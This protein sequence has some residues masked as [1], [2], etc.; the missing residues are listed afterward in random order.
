M[1]PT[2][3]PEASQ[4]IE[5]VRSLVAR[6]FPV[7][8]V[9][10][11]YDV[12]QFFCRV[13]PATLEESFE[14][15]RQEMAEHNY[16]PMITYDKGEHIVQ[17]ARKP[18][19]RYRSI[20]VNI[21]FLI[22]TFLTML[23]AGVLDWVSYSSTPPGETWSPHSIMMGVLTFTLPLMAILS[24][25]ELAHYFMARR[26][27]VAASLPFFIPSFP[28]LGTF[29]AFISLRDPIP[30]KKA[31][32][33]IGA[34][35]PLAGLALAIPIGIYGLILT[36]EGAMPPPVNQ[37]GNV[38]GIS[39]PLLY[40]WLERFFPITGDYLLH[41]TAFAA[42][43]GILVTGLNL[44]PVGQLDGGHIARALLGEKSKYL[45]W[46]TVAALVAMSFLYFGWIIFAILVLFLGTRHPPT[47]NDISHIG[48]SRT[49]V[50][51]LAFVVLLLTFVPQPMV[52]I[53]ADYS[54]DVEPQGET[55]VTILPGGSYTLG[56]V[57]TNTG[58]AYNEILIAGADVPTG[59]EVSFV[60]AHSNASRSGASLLLH[61]N[62]SES[63]V[64]NASVIASPLEV[65]GE[66]RSVVIRATSTNSSESHDVRLNFTVET[67]SL[68]YWLVD[69]SVSIPRG[70]SANITVQLNNSEGRNLSV[71]LRTN[72]T[73]PSNVDYLLW[74][75]WTDGAMYPEVNLTVPAGGSATFVV[76]VMV[77]P[78]ASP[79]AASV[80]VD[81]HIDEAVVLRV[82]VTFWIA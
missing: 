2:V 82:P 31:L 72:E 77:G 51:V 21:G 4:E 70:F 59:W 67:P 42:W 15:L 78:L 68:V 62:S 46:A 1:A 48:R 54:F 14:N 19:A 44:L 6:H 22:V 8:D 43:V 73:R 41:P 24:V 25:H 20:Y 30:N 76:F 63:A 47:L 17:V 26:R 33:E 52:T 32:M 3:P 13:D 56:L 38:V 12:V 69:S 55:D 27:K 74:T 34:A 18:E 45:S 36:N 40:S 64:L 28:P 66:T 11:N 35:G 37:A 75:D 80:S 61:L 7:Y 9:R 49:A 29:G 10:V 65:S 57:V 5:F 50:G 79:G 81:V 16:I 60:E 71:T 58:N 53:A 39:F 23:F